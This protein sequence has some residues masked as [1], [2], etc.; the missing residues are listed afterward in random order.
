MT[1]KHVIK[2]KDA[3]LADGLVRYNGDLFRR[4]R[5]G[6]NRLRVGDGPVVFRIEGTWMSSSIGGLRITDG[7]A[8]YRVLM[9]TG[10]GYLEWPRLY[11]PVSSYGD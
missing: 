6:D 9:P 4:V 7:N 3:P 5:G 8:E 11:V 1:I 2:R 10:W